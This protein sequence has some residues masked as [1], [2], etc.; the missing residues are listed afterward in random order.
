MRPFDRPHADPCET[1]ATDYLATDPC[2]TLA[3]TPRPVGPTQ[4]TLQPVLPVLPVLPDEL[5]LLMLTFTPAHA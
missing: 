5:W 3:S 1:M 2:A 4:A